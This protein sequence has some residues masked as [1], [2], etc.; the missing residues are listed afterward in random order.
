MSTLP[1]FEGQLPGTNTVSSIGKGTLALRDISFLLADKGAA[2]DSDYRYEPIKLP[3]LSGDIDHDQRHRPTFA[4]LEQPRGTKMVGMNDNDHIVVKPGETARIA[5]SGLAGCTAVGVVATFPDG[6]RRAHVQHYDPFGSRMVNGG[7]TGQPG[8][9]EMIL[10]REAERGNYSGASRV[11]A[12]I[13]IPSQ[14]HIHPTEPEHADALEAA[15][16][17]NF[18]REA[19]VTVQ[20]YSPMI[21]HGEGPYARAFVIDIP[22][23]GTPELFPGLY[24]IQTAE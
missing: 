2:G 16:K 7:G 24:R 11:D 10:A 5:T 1:K 4:E 6:H 9:D 12:A 22:A 20:P 17:D 14:D 18:G 15:I 8:L 19:H 13:M 21:S 23:A 3:S